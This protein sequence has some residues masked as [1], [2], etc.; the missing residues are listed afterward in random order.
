MP[1]DN[2]SCDLMYRLEVDNS[3]L[4]ALVEDWQKLGSEPQEAFDWSR[5][6]SNWQRD[7]PEYKEYIAQLPDSIDRKFLRELILK[8]EFSA[9]EKFL[10]VMIWGYGDIGYGSYR[11]NKMFGSIAV[12]EKIAQ[13]FE[14][15][16]GAK[17]LQAYEFLAKYRISQ[18]G[19]AFGT[20]LISFFTPREI[21]AP[22]YDSFI[23]KWMDKYS[24][25]IF[26]NGSCSSEVWNLKTYSTYSNWINFHSVSFGCFSDDLELVIFRDA[27]EQFSTSSGWAGQQ[28]PQL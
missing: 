3:R 11:V 20:K 12:E 9:M 4:R 5:S 26:E 6:A 13:V 21:V 17:P 16:Q 2:P 27:L 24:K 18:L 22:I 1:L 14:L 19:P 10:A 23:W 25:D 15:C 7:L 28:E 8:K